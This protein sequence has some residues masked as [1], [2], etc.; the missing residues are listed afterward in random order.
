M[1]SDVSRIVPL[2]MIPALLN[3]M[4]T[5]PKRSTVSATTRSQYAL[6]RTSP[7]TNAAQP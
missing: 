1:S 2:G 6:S 5:P 7:A 3:G 4:S